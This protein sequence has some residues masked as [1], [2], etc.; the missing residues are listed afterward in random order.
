MNRRSL[1]KYITLGGGI[2]AAGVA[3]WATG[4]YILGSSKKDNREVIKQIEE[5]KDIIIFKSTYGKKIENPNH[6]G[7]QYEPGTRKDVQIK[8]VVGPDGHLYLNQNGG[9]AKVLIET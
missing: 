8:F 3:G 6:L 9:W 5:Q 7:T 1:L 2:A 4:G